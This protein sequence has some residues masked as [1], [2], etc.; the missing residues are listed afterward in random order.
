MED[1]WQLYQEIEAQGKYFLP[2]S[3]NLSDITNNLEDSNRMNA[4]TKTSFF[5]RKKSEIK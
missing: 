2:I 1:C 4:A 3:E 5:R